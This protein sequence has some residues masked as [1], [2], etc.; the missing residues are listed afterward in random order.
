MR[1]QVTKAAEMLFDQ[2]GMTHRFVVC[3]DRGDYDLGSWTRVSGLQV[4]WGTVGYRPGENDDE[5]VYS[6]RI[7]YPNI[8]LARAACADSAT[9]KAWLA[10]TA[11]NPEALS[12]AVQ[13]LDFAGQPVVTWELTRFFPVSWAITG[14]DSTSARPAIEELQLAHTGFLV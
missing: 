5:T 7:S 4:S 10:R 8:T 2:V 1:Q 13:M 6:G 9:V 14:F 12:G 3:I 11:H